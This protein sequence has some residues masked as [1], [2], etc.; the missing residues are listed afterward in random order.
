MNCKNSL[1]PPWE[2]RGFCYSSQ[3]AYTHLT[4]KLGPKGPQT[5]PPSDAASPRVATQNSLKVSKGASVRLGRDIRLEMREGRAVGTKLHWQEG[6]ACD[7]RIVAEIIKNEG[8]L[9]RQQKKIV[10]K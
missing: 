7:K 9:Y 2:Q 8:I 3:A 6:G 10:L 1:G 4:G 5:V